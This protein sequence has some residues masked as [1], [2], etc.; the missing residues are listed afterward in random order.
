MFSLSRLGAPL[1]SSCNTN[2]ASCM[3]QSHSSNYS[4]KQLNG[5]SK[6]VHN[7]SFERNGKNQ[8]G[9]P[10]V[11]RKRVHLE[12]EDGKTVT[13]K[14]EHYEIDQDAKG[15][16]VIIKNP[17]GEEVHTEYLDSK[18]STKDKAKHIVSLIKKHRQTLGPTL[19]NT[20]SHDSENHDID[21]FVQE[22]LDGPDRGLS[23]RTSRALSRKRARSSS[24]SSK[25]SGR[26]S[27]Q[28]RRTSSRS[29]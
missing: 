8:Q 21:S 22:E 15:K 13:D 6:V 9:K 4:Y 10:V 5:K 25:P 18:L 23:A 14:F 1:T 12:T 28:R 26:R 29:K 20:S 27:S 3:S 11:E 24:K 7:E 2:D 19:E 17:A 16:F